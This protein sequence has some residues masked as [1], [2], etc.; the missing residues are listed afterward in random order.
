[1]NIQMAS[2]EELVLLLILFSMGHKVKGSSS[3]QEQGNAAEKPHIV[4]M[5]VDDWR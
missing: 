1:M 4:F 2:T 3:K 5:M